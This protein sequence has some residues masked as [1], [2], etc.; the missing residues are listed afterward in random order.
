MM[1]ASS[2]W[3]M[4]CVWNGFFQEHF[5]FHWC[6]VIFDFD[7]SEKLSIHYERELLTFCM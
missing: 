7:L 4:K 6:D 1:Q 5:E 3:K 2:W